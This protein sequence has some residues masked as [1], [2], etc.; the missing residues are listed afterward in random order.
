MPGRGSDPGQTD[1]GQLDL[2]TNTNERFCWNYSQ[3]GDDS[4]WFLGRADESRA[5]NESPNP[6][7]QSRG[8]A[9]VSH[10][11]ALTCRVSDVSAPFSCS[12]K[13]HLQNYKKEKCQEP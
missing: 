10:F 3:I 13:R 9:L 8:P 12:E 5:A 4:H 7:V 1:P 2:R 11:V 6:N